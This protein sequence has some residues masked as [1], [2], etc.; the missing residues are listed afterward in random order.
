MRSL[1]R[2]F[3]YAVRNL[4]NAPLFTTIAVLSMAL[5]I[6]ANT[7]VFTL[8]DQV[9]L[10]KLPV[11]DPKAIV[12][13][14]ARETENNGVTM[15]DGTELSF[16]MYRDLKDHNQVFTGMFCRMPTSLHVGYAGRTEQVDGELVSGTFFPE[17]GIRPALGRLFTHAEDRSPGGHP[18]TVLGYRYWQTRFG[19]DESIIGRTIHVNS[20]PLEVVGV[21]QPGFAGLDIGRPTQVYVP[22]TMQPRMGPAW[23]KLDDR[24]ARWVQ[25]FARLR[26]GLTVKDAQTGLQPL[27]RSLLLAESKDAAFAQT[28]AD[29]KRRFLEGTLTVED[30]SRGHSGLRQSVTEPLLIL[31][32][33]SGGVL[34]IVCASMANLL[35]ARG[36][37]RHR[38]VALRLAIGAGPGQIIRLM[39]AETVLLGA[40]GAGL[41]IVLAGWGAGVLLGFFVTPDSAMAVTAAADG[42]ILLF[43]AAL[44]LATALGA[45]I[46]PALR[47]TRVDLAPSLKGSGGGVVAEQPRLRKTLV[48][49]QVALSFV[50]LIGA[51]L[52]LRS[53]RNLLEVDPGFETSQVVT[54]NFDLSRSG[55]EGERATAFAETLLETIKTVPGVGS[56]AISFQPLLDGGG[57]G[58]P[59]TIEGYQPPAG[60]S[61]QS[62]ANSVTPGFFGTLQV[63]LIAGREFTERD[64]RSTARAQGWPYSIAIVN[65]TFVKRYFRGQNPI[66]GRIGIGDSLGTDMPIEIVG[67]VKDTRYAAIREEATPQVFFP[68]LQANIEYA[69]AYVRTDRDPALVVQSIRRAVAGLDPQLALYGIGTL[70]E[71]VMRSVVNERLIASLSAT[72]ASIATLLAI[73]GLYGVMAYTVTRRTREI[74]IRM[75]LGALRSQIAGGILREAGV[76]VLIG[77]SIGFAAAW[78]LGRYVQNQLYGVVPADSTTIALAAC[79]LSAVAALASLVPARRAAGVSPISALREE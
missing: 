78:W 18:V 20:Q 19:G 65:E 23:L 60:E 6:A 16:P 67:Y 1:A 51:G 52:F 9:V 55:Y 30:A 76:L 29:T 73:I 8:V 37:A 13:V 34:V 38:E 25:V 2:D 46:L 33:I 10:R 63:P 48:V 70:E 54:F 3:Q 22:I 72:L 71:R 56:A 44:A 77:L 35:I 58:M 7:A 15:G 47:S 27:Y 21:V 12:Q 11:A 17:L 26:E 14:H 50:L 75:A 68:Y 45:G 40:L 28:S 57:W 24:R 64:G 31:M 69:T 59:F 61:A 74:G 41:G 32:A 5:G 4:R 36:V 42:R 62:A 79:G 49:V 39:L 53:L 66:G 43:T